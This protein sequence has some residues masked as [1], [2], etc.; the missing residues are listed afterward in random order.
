LR[1][2]RAEEGTNQ[3]SRIA[4]RAPSSDATPLGVSADRNSSARQLEK[5]V[6]IFQ[7]VLVLATFSCSL[8]AGFLLA[9]AIV[10][11][12]GIRRLDDGGFIRAFQVIDGVVQDRPPVFVFVW[13]GSVLA[14]VAAAVLGT[15]ALSGFDRVLVIVGALVYLFCVQL[16][17]VA[18]NIPL[19]NKLQ[20]LDS[21]IMNDTERAQARENFEGRWNRWNAIRTACA[22]V[23]S[24]VLMVLL[25]RV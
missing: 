7:A 25:L 1:R 20:K 6:T 12:P 23:V 21:R 18:I 22:S 4:F 5:N 16:P 11:M 17:T 19:N 3:R 13:V 24:I 14:V 9:F 10:V 8:V 15:W 2:R